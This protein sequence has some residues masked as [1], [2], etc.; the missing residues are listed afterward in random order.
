MWPGTYLLVIAPHCTRV[1]A[2][3]LSEDTI[4][5]KEAQNFSIGVKRTISLWPLALGL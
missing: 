1:A 2:K 5:M 4:R 3:L